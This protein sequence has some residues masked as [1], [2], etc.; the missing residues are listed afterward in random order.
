[1][2]FAATKK[3]HVAK[4]PLFATL[5]QDN[6]FEIVYFT[7]F[8]S[9]FQKT[10]THR[11]WRRIQRLHLP[12]QEAKTSKNA[13]IYIQHFSAMIFAKMCYFWTVLRFP[14]PHLRF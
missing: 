14:L 2:G 8:W 6:M 12:S 9:T 10:H 1:V 3:A 11:K 7:V 4:T 13:D 5:W